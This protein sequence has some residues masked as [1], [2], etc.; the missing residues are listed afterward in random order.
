[1]RPFEIFESLRDPLLAR[2]RGVSGLVFVGKQDCIDYLAAFFGVAS[3]HKYVCIDKPTFTWEGSLSGRDTLVLVSEDEDALA[4][5]VQRVLTQIGRSLR[6]VRLFADLF[7]N[8]V[9]GGDLWQTTSSKF[10]PPEVAYGIIGTPRCGSE[11]LCELLTSTQV[12]GYPQEHL[13][14]HSLLLA[15]HCRFDTNRYLKIL[16]SRRV[17]P[18]RVFG[19]KLISHFLM[20]HLM[21]SSELEGTLSRFKFIRVLR[22][23]VL[24]QA[25][26]AMLASRTEVYHVRNEAEQQRYTE[27][28]IGI[29]IRSTDLLHVDQ[30]IRAF[31][32]QNRQI[33]DFLCRHGISPLLLTYEDLIEQPLESVK[34]IA[35]FLNISV[36]IDSVSAGVRRI[37][38]PLSN[39][40]RNLYIERSKRP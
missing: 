35:R 5:D 20:D 36:R 29:E 2:L 4:A 30:L 31:S 17:T 34:N 16:M 38:S 9:S 6:V 18:N 21:M 12:A 22:R 25:I 10:A 7:V 8:A 33:D 26:S 19:T 37:E 1:M 28:L 27:R 23:D 13:R 11:F 39:T 14:T 15:K 40:V 24:G 3:L 32:T